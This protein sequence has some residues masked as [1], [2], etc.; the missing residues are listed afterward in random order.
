M[1]TALQVS[2]PVEWAE[3]SAEPAVG[4]LLGQWRVL[5][6]PKSSQQQ[7]RALAADLDVRRRGAGSVEKTK[8]ALQRECSERCAQQGQTLRS[9]LD[10]EAWLAEQPSSVAA[11]L[12]KSGRRLREKPLS[13]EAVRHLAVVLRVP[14]SHF[15]V[16]ALLDRCRQVWFDR[17]AALR[18]GVVSPCRK[19][20]AFSVCSVGKGFRVELKGIWQGPV[21]TQSVEAYAA[22]VALQDAGV[23]ECQ[24]AAGPGSH[25]TARGS[26]AFCCF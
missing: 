13:R 6:D 3:Q 12:L 24:L 17:V 5:Q 8:D 26:A 14:R 9:H 19:Q 20:R 4:A 10:C 7:V 18:A 22:R 23:R 21:R 2:F 1:A 11:T 16:E 25:I 15:E